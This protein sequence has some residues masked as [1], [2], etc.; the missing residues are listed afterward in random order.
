M[1]KYARCENFSCI[2]VRALQRRNYLRS[3]PSVLLWSADGGDVRLIAELHILSVFQPVLVDGSKNGGHKKSP[4]TGPSAISAA[5]VLGS[6]ALARVKEGYVTSVLQSFTGQTV[7][8]PA[9]VAL[10]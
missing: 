3:T 6:S 4:S 7:A 10:A 1:L 8:S 9:G 5:N 2:D